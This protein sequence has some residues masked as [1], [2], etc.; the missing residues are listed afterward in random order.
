MDG[1]QINRSPEREH[2][3][4]VAWAESAMKTNSRIRKL[5][6]S[7]ESRG[8]PM[9]IGVNLLCER[10]DQPGLNG[11]FDAE[12][13]EAVVC[14]NAVRNGQQVERVLA[15]E[16]VHAYDHCRAHVNWSYL[17]HWACS[18]VRAA[19]LSGECSLTVSK[20][21]QTAAGMMP[22]RLHKGGVD[23]ARRHAIRSLQALRSDLEM[24]EIETA[25]DSVFVPCYL[26]SE[27]FDVIPPLT[28]PLGWKPR[29]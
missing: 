25:V 10:C 19:A 21:M 7:L 5:L 6:E 28:R 3:D 24:A 26:D 29:K 14:E 1:P 15:H 20:F 23:C 8:C 16:L 22:W 9:R 17:P 4:C 18:E 2:A 13:A 27:P 11:G 12:R